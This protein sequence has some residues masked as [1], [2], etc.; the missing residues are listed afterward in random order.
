M[1]GVPIVIKAIGYPE[2]LEPALDRPGGYLQ[3][4]ANDGVKITTEKSNNIT[5]PKYEGVYSSEHLKRGDK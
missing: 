5:I 4:M 3:L 1:V 2:R